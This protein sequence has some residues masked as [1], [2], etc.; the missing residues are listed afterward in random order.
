MLQIVVKHVVH[1]TE[2]TFRSFVFREMPDNDTAQ[3]R[4]DTAYLE[5][6]EHAVDLRHGLAG[7]FNEQDQALVSTV[8][9]VVFRPCQT[10]KHRH[11]A[12]DKHARSL[13]RLIKGM[14]IDTIGG[15][16]TLQNVMKHGVDG[17][18]HRSVHRQ[19]LTHGTMNAHH[20][21]RHLS[22]MQGRHVAE[23][24]QPFRMVGKI[25]QWNSHQ[26]LNG[27]IAATTA[28]DGAHRTV[29]QRP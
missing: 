9:K 20:T 12:T 28:Q 26:Q 1:I 2:S 8:K 17:V 25:I 6:M 24:H 22:T 21:C 4:Q 11:I 5:Q 13:A 16:M 14:G 18:A 23:A 10:A 29:A 27:T 15:Q 7:V 3:L 19:S